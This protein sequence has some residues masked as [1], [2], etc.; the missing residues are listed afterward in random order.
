RADLGDALAAQGHA[1][2][3][4]PESRAAA[5]RA[6]PRHLVALDHEPV[7]GLVGLLLQ[8]LE[9]RD[10]AAELLAA[11]E[12]Q[13][14]M[15]GRQLAPRLLQRDAHVL[16][17]SLQA[18]PGHRAPR[19]G[20]RGERTVLERLVVVRDDQLGREREHVAEAAAGRADAERAVEREQRWLG[21]Q[22]RGAAVGALPTFVVTRRRR[23][24]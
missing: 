5:V 3:L 4:G 23:L 19:A 7:A 11:L 6:R 10:H 8:A 9:E 2:R 21:T 22:R 17:E 14:A 15:R 12:Q 24:P 13:L 20:P 1:Q 16:R 18:R